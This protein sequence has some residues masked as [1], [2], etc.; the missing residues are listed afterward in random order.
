MY[1]TDPIWTLA[2]KGPART[3]AGI[4]HPLL[5][6]VDR[7]PESGDISRDTGSG[8]NLELD[9]GGRYLLAVDRNGAGWR[10][11]SGWRYKIC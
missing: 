6:P 1:L 7:D 9:R 10:L 4:K 11:W 3:R 5:L 8:H 2:G